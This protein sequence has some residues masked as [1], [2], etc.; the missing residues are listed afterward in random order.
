MNFENPNAARRLALPA[1][2][3]AGLSEIT[4]KLPLTEDLR[5]RAQGYDC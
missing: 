5:V 4:D 3:L 1:A 2:L